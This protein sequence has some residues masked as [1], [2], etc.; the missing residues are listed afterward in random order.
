[1][2]ERLQIIRPLVAFDDIK[3]GDIRAVYEFM[4][5]HQEFLLENETVYNMTQKQI[6]DRIAKKNGISERTIK[7][8]VASYREAEQEMERKGE[9]GLVTKARTGYI[10]RQ[11][12]KTL[13]ICH[14]KDPH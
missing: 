5:Y 12:N 7:R 2:S 6:I 1:M 4:E 8:Y 13:E 9:E 11:D 3:A 14:P 10:H